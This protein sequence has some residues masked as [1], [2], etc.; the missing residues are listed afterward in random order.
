MR[1]S[2]I[3]LPGVIAL[4]L[5]VA[6]YG[7]SSAWSGG[8]AVSSAP[9]GMVWIPGGEFTMGSDD[10]KARADERPTHRARV[11]GFWMDKR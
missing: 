11:D 4:G 7:V 3:L 10:P 2:F 9:A 8:A 1:A 5:A 6:V